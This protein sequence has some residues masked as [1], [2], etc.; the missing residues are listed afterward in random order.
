MAIK[1]K[2]IIQTSGKRFSFGGADSPKIA[3]WLNT[4]FVIRR[5][6]GEE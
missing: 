1:F 5:K 2:R 4:Q 3:P 6:K